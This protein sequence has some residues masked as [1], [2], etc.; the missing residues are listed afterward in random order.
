MSTKFFGSA[1][2]LLVLLTV[3]FT[4]CASPESSPR[5][6]LNMNTDWAF[7]RGD[8]IGAEK[9]QYDDSNWIPVVVP[10]V[11]QL[12][13]KHCGGNT[14][15]DG[16]GWY[17]RYFTLSEDYADKRIIVSFEGVMKN[18]ELFLNGHKLNEHFGGYIG[19][20]VDLTDYLNWSGENVLALRV[21]AAD[22]PYTPPGKPQGQMD[23]YYYSGIYRDVNLII[24]D[25][26]F[27][28]DALEEDIVAGGGQFI[29][30][31][32]VTRQQATVDVATH[33]RN[34]HAAIQNVHVVT[35]LLNAKGKKVS[36]DEQRFN[37]DAGADITLSQQLN[38]R[39]PSLWHP[40]SPYLYTLRTRIYSN[41]KLVDE[42]QNT[43]GIR[44]IHYT[45]E[46]GFF[47]NGEHVYMRGANRHQSYPNV[48]DAASNSMQEREVIQ[49]KQGGYNSVRAAH[50]PQDPAFLAACDKYGLLV[51]ECIP[52]WQFFNH[53]S[54]FI[55]RTYQVGRQMIRRDRNHPSIVLWETALNESHYPVSIA[56]KLYEIAHEEYPGG[57]M[58]T[59]GDY[60]GHQSMEPY[61][62]VLYKQVNKFPADGNVMSNYPEDFISIK[63]LLTREW[64]DGVGEKPR[65]SL[66]ENEEEQM[67][68]SRSRFTQLNGQGYFDWCMLDANPNMGGHY[69][70]S[71]NDYAR[72]MG[73][74]TLYCGVV[75]INR[76]PKFSYFML[77]SMRDASISQKGLY[78]GPMVHIASFNSGAEFSSSTTDITVFSNCDEVRLFRNDQLIGVQTREE[79]T[80]LYQPIVDKGGSPCFIF[81]A[82]GYEAGELRAEAYIRGKRVATHSVRTPEAP[83]HIVVDIATQGIVPVADGSDMIPVYFRIC[84]AN[85][86]LISDSKQ[87]I[88]IDV[89]GEGTL[90]GDGIARVEINPQTVEGGVGFAFI[91]VS[92]NAGTIQVTASADGLESGKA[93]VTTVPFTGQYV[94]VGQERIFTGHEEDNVVVKPTGWQ[95]RVLLRPRIP[96]EGVTVT[97][98]HAVYPAS[99]IIDGDDY[100]WWLADS[101]LLPQVI[102]VALD[103]AQ[104][105]TASRIRFQKDSSAYKHKVETSTDGESWV[106][107]Y[108]REC[109]G[110]DFKPQRIGRQMKYLRLTI[111]GVSEG[112][113]GLAQISLY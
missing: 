78:D 34:T 101:D 65:V 82:G 103:K 5:I 73:E 28:T 11:M 16:V 37:L 55:E 71:Y 41:D 90:I 26:L 105:V 80:P 2:V 64:G 98:S 85:G 42:I 67:R 107:I 20:V 51:I 21:C 33:L 56:R 83:H 110:W 47:I 70:W 1:T 96:I 91:R 86:T 54:T 60:F 79:R 23:F 7:F 39:R 106:E 88:H 93:S 112:S 8:T 48:G 40:Y 61:Y 46:E 50:Y 102:T 87:R 95:E 38:V 36:T 13:I 57:Q 12:E 44:T 77:Q 81:D 53:D 74:T 29:R 25:K 52:G 17:R 18:S 113:A 31:P 72:G 15:Y 4:G 100:S 58:Y 92:K 75:D 43:I 24:T 19:F 3:F 9:I 89:Q 104:H 59:A 30:Y 32:E 99:H 49:L 94:P 69:V 97:S 84:D 66:T 10:H 62:D 108:D 6:V 27:V 63:P 22:D 109:T 111:Y 45:K 68:Q 14:I 35:D 76:H